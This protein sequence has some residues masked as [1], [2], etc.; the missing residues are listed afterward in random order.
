MSDVDTNTG[1]VAPSDQGGAPPVA[2]ETPAESAPAPEATDGLA[3]PADGEEPAKTP[4]SVQKSINRLTRQRAEAERRALRAEAQLEVMQSSRTQPQPAPQPSAGLKQSDFASYDDF[5]RAQARQEARDAVKEELTA[6]QR[7][8]A[9]Q[10]A[11]ETQNQ[12]MDAFV[13]EAT[14]QGAAAGIDFE[15]AWDTLTTAPRVSPA[16]AEFLFEAEHKA[17]IADHLARNP[18]ELARLSDLPP[19]S[20]VRELARLEVRLSAKPVPRTTNAPPPGPTVGGRSVAALNPEKMSMDEY[21]VYW[22]N[23]KQAKG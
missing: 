2:A 5:I 18:D 6:S 8:S 4:A 17:M 10:R 7:Q 3:P 15:D 16:V 14:K 1:T 22:N 19:I 21:R 9:E 11:T 13:K 23:R 12:R 20:A